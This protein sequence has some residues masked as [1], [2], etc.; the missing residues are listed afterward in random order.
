MPLEVSEFGKYQI[1]KLILK[2]FV[3]VRCVSHDSK[4]NEMWVSQGNLESQDFENEYKIV[5]K[6]FGKL[7]LCNRCNFHPQRGSTKIDMAKWGV[8][9]A[10]WMS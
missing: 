4:L 7:N 6:S 1:G 9:Y 10:K 2:W 8:A 5:A 3:C